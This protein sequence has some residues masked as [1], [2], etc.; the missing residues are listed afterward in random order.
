MYPL[1]HISRME[2]YQLKQS[3]GIV[4][5]FNREKPLK[6]PLVQLKFLADV[7]GVHF[8]TQTILCSFVL[9]HSLWH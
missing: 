9:W 7:S 1:Y 6:L 4:H 2:K 8:A 5:I 3:L